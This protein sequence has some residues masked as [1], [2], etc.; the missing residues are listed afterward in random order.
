M[1][2]NRHWKNRSPDLSERSPQT[3]GPGDRGVEEEL[4]R[5]EPSMREQQDAQEQQNQGGNGQARRSRNGKRGGG[6]SMGGKLQFSRRGKNG[7]EERPISLQGGG[8]GNA[9][10]GSEAM[11]NDSG[12]PRRNGHARL[13]LEHASAR[14]LAHFADIDQRTA[15]KIIRF[16]NQRGSLDDIDDL[17]QV[18]GVDDQVLERLRR[19]AA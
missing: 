6:T 3:P 13:D 9:E 4:A 19:R 14:D 2:D 8:S 17:R 11:R 15:E 7:A 5:R 1:A 12:D 10:L 18:D 16:R